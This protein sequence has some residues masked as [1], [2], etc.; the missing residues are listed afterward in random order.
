MKSFTKIFFILF[1][2][3]LI[4]SNSFAQGKPDPVKSAT[5]DMLIGT[6][7]S[8]PYEMMGSTWT[9]TATH[10]WK[11]NG[12]YMFIDISGKDD[13]GNTYSGTVVIIPKSDGTF[14]GY[15]FD[16]YGGNSTISGKA[17]GSK[18][19][20]DGKS[21][22]GTDTRDIEINGNTM[23]HKISFTMKDKDGKDMTQNMTVTYTKK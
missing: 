15:G 18:I 21:A 19:H 2:F 20:G 23:V 16:D 3:I 12:Q 9:E 22:W 13:K 6:W 4:S 17:D 10:S 8:S 5:I 11:H 7:V 14:T 1:T